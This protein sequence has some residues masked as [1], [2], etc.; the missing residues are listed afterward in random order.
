MYVSCVRILYEDVCVLGGQSLRLS[1]FF[2]QGLDQL[3][4]VLEFLQRG[5]VC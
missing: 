3:L 4:K 1:D 5:R 2:L